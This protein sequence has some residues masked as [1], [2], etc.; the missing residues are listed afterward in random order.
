[1]LMLPGLVGDSYRRIGSPAGRL[2]VTNDKVRLSP[3][4]VLMLVV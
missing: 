1:M 3:R 4:R 2:F